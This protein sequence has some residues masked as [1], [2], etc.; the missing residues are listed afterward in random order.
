MALGKP[1]RAAPGSTSA[2]SSSTS[3]TH[4]PSIMPSCSA[5]QAPLFRRSAVSGSN[6]ALIADFLANLA[7]VGG[8][9]NGQS[10][11]PFRRPDRPVKRKTAPRWNGPSCVRVALRIPLP[12]GT[13]FGLIFGSPPP[14]EAVPK[15][16]TS[17]GL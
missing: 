14:S 5:P 8:Q 4:S 17:G 15:S 2:R 13:Q 7:A 9:K 10:V 3:R 16:R 11:P 12:F 6:Q 1:S